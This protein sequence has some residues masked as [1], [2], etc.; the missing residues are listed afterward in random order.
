MTLKIL[1]GVQGTGNG[2][3]AR[4]RA[5]LPALKN[6]DV[7]IDFVF[8]GRSE[9]DFF[10]M[11]EYGNYRVFRGLTLIYKDSIDQQSVYLHRGC[12]LP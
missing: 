7:E 11:Q 5:L 2:H 6:K 8:S 10:D 4:T 9:E 3:I 12:H 1:Y